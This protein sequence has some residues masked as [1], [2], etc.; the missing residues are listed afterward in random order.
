MQDHVE[1]RGINV[2][3]SDY[4]HHSIETIIDQRQESGTGSSGLKRGRPKVQNESETCQLSIDKR[5]ALG[6]E[7]HITCISC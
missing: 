5:E 3:T 7:A 6:D 4:V 1:S 2:S